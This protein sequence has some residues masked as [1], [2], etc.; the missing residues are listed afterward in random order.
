MEEAAKME[1]VA[2]I[3]MRE[4]RGQREEESKNVGRVVF[5]SA[6][7]A[8]VLVMVWIVVTNIILPSFSGD[9]EDDEKTK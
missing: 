9:D 8:F 2:T 4:G 3:E 1:E 6:A 5:V 7:F